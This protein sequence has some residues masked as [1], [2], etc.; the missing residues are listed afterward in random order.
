MATMSAPDH[1]LDGQSRFTEIITILAVGGAVTTG[2]VALRVYVRARLLRTF[3]AEDAF[4]IAAQCLAIGTAVCI[5]LGAL[6]MHPCLAQRLLT[7]SC[8]L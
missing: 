2:V 5:G 1:T 4:M 3:G 8:A 6:S 7:G